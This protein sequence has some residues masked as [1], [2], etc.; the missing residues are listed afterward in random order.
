MPDNQQDRP[1]PLPLSDHIRS[2][3][4]EQYYQTG[5]IQTCRRRTAEREIVACRL[6]AHGLLRI[7]RL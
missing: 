5:Y 1:V 2:M 4:H 6:E 7:T 3:A